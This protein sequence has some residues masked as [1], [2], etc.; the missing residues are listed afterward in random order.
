MLQILK[1]IKKF[2]SLLVAII[3]FLL[4]CAYLFFVIVFEVIIEKETHVDDVIYQEIRLINTPGITDAFSTLTFFGS[5]IFLTSAYIFLVILLFIRRQRKMALFIAII[6]L[7]STLLLFTL[8]FFFRRERP[9]PLVEQVAGFSFPSGHSFSGFIFYGILIYF[10]WLTNWDQPIKWVLSALLF[11]FALM[12]AISRVFLGHHFASDVLAG[13]C[14][15]IIWVS[16]AILVRNKFYNN[17]HI[18]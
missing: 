7:G 16:V 3:L 14:L 17:E 1:Q 6:S 10:L 4:S 15:S 8:K 5:P 12:V 13:F 2:S 9:E 11:L 18:N